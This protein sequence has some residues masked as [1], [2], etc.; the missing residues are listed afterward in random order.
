MEIIYKKSEYNGRTRRSEAVITSTYAE[1]LEQLASAQM[2][3]ANT[4]RVLDDPALPPEQ[5][6]ALEAEAEKI[7]ATIAGAKALVD[8]YEG[9]TV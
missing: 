3:L 5:K 9:G 2:Q 8:G 4:I 7:R 1:D 6:A